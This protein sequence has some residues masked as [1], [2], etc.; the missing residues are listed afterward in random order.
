MVITGS[1][2]VNISDPGVIVA[3]SGITTP[4]VT[5]PD[6]MVI[7]SGSLGIPDTNSGVIVMTTT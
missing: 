5:Q 1:I 7:L 3:S 6:I 2:L 4:P